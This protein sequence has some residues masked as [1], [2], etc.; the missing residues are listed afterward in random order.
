MSWISYDVTARGEPWRHSTWPKALLNFFGYYIFFTCFTC[1]IFFVYEVLFSSL[2]IRLETSQTTFVEGMP[3]RVANIP[4]KPFLGHLIPPP[5]ALF[6][7]HFAFGSV[8][9]VLR[10]KTLFEKSL[11][12]PVFLKLTQLADAQVICLFSADPQILLNSE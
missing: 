12:K 9:K 4:T 2:C 3:G 7:F 6:N 8:E 11:S 5:G 1:H 10:H